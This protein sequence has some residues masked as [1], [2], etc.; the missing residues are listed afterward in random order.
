[1]MKNFRFE[2]LV[3]LQRLMYNHL[4]TGFILVL[5]STN[6]AEAFGLVQLDAAITANII[7][8]AEVGTESSNLFCWKRGILQNKVQ[9]CWS[10]F[11]YSKINYKPQKHGRD[12]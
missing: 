3:R 6:N 4:S 7:I 10:N 11:R 2:G 8:T 9:P 5:P 12:F 1:M